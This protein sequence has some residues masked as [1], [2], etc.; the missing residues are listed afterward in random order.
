MPGFPAT[1]LVRQNQSKTMKTSQ[2]PGSRWGRKA[3][4][5]RAGKA[6]AVVTEAELQEDEWEH[7]SACTA[8]LPAFS[9]TEWISSPCHETRRH[10]GTHISCVCKLLY[11]EG[12]DGG[13]I[14]N[15]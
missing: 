1:T 13:Q 8:Q 11:E 6:L 12:E 15:N 10:M 7:F 5:L 2:A 14:Q 4:F 9:A 3:E